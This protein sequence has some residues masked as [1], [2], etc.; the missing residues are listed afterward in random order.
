MTASD[1]IKMKVFLKN[2]KKMIVWDGEICYR[3]YIYIYI[4]LFTPYVLCW[5]LASI[6]IKF[7]QYVTHSI[8]FFVKILWK[9]MISFTIGSYYKY[10]QK[11]NILDMIQKKKCFMRCFH[12]ILNVKLIFTHEI[13]LAVGHKRIC[14]YRK[15]NTKYFTK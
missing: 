11:H 15:L 5:T 10:V 14:K 12:T 7:L 13:E 9:Y 2:K 8:D 1:C 3:V 4:C 6:N